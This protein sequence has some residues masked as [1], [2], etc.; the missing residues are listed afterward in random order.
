VPDAGWKEV[1]RK[2][3]KVSVPSNAISRVIGRGGSNINAIRE[4]SGAHIEVE[5]QSKGQG[6]RTILIK[7]SA[8]ATRNAHTW[9]TAIIASPVSAQIGFIR[10][11]TNPIGPV[12]TCLPPQ[13]KDLAD[14]VG[15]QQYKTLSSVNL[16]KGAQATVVVT[17]TVVKTVMTTT[18]SAQGQ[19]QKSKSGQDVKKL[20]ALGGAMVTAVTATA[21]KM[22]VTYSGAAVTTG[23]KTKPVT[24]TSFAAI[25]A[26]Q[27]N[28]G[29]IPTGPPPASALKPGQVGKAPGAK[30]KEPAGLRRKEEQPP[31]LMPPGSDSKDYSPFKTFKMPGGG[32]VNWGNEKETG[33]SAQGGFKGFGG[34][35]PI[36]VSQ[37][38]PE[39]LAKAPGYRQQQPAGP[40][41]SSSAGQVSGWQGGAAV[42]AQAVTSLAPGYNKQMVVTTTTMVTNV[43]TTEQIQST[44]RSGLFPTQERCNS[45]PG[46]P[47]SP[48]VTPSPIA[49]PPSQAAPSG[50]KPGATSS[51][52]SEPDWFARPSAGGPLGHGLRSMTPDGDLDRGWGG[53][54]G[55]DLGGHRE[56]ARQ[57]TG[58]YGH[59]SPAKAPGAPLG[60]APDLFGR[61]SKMDPA[62]QSEQQNLLSA[63]A[64]LSGLGQPGYGDLLPS[65][66][67]GI[68]LP[69]HSS[70]GTCLPPSSSFS[71][72]GRF[73]GGGPGQQPRFTSPGQSTGLVFS[74]PPTMSVP[75]AKGLN[76]NAPDFN[77]GA[78]MY[79]QRGVGPARPGQGL[80]PGPPKPPGAAGGFAGYNSFGMGS[81]FG[82]NPPQPVGANS[83]NILINQGINAYLSSLG[84]L[85][86][87][88]LG[89]APPALGDMGM[90]GLAGLAEMSLGGRTLSELTDMLGP[91]A[92]PGYNPVSSLGEHEL[93]S[94]LSSLS[95]LSSL[96]QGPACA[97]IGRPIGAER[98][99]LGPSPLGA[100]MGPQARK[101]DP[102]GVWDLPP[103]YADN[104]AATTMATDRS[105]GNVGDGGSNFSLLPPSLTGQTLQSA[106]DNLSKGTGFS[107][108][109]Y[110]GGGRDGQALDPGSIGGQTP[111]SG[112]G[113]SPSITPGKVDYS[114]WGTGST[115]G[116]APPSGGKGPG[117]QDPYRGD[118]AAVRRNMVR[119][120]HPPPPHYPSPFPPPPPDLPLLQN[121]MWPKEWGDSA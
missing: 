62:G 56:Q 70:A 104:I 109:Q 55:E 99:R 50:P 85:S 81:S 113:L 87:G 65:S 80:Q 48:L 28:F 94:G 30:E 29:M 46:T 82:V 18:G 6:D 121:Q 42:S 119:D 69:D 110:N 102:F 118:P 16:T 41:P 24:S 108:L 10:F 77:R 97:P 51:P 23:A 3:K 49:P 60:G 57:G 107:D 7:G 78:G 66:T 63:A 2:S 112:F 35:G 13:D 93:G 100:G 74:Q 114:D 88:G 58:S 11:E 71:G 120:Q 44:G 73:G 14:I 83:Q 19:V 9:I 39:E 86:G 40:G 89:P 91:E 53:L 106:L 95:S 25:A 84:G 1:V 115:S 101:V 54:R 90:S 59:N 34:P 98:Q 79:G 45:A 5:K 67:A 103:S 21:T 15:R 32:F 12:V 36:A 68:P 17:K 105:G 64:Q 22:T 52:G 47:I 4:L 8:E 76:P 31:P 43:T 111:G 37:S 96:R 75:G 26:G 92:V 116:S 117:H 33:P 72:F 38:G 20:G 61:G 27:D